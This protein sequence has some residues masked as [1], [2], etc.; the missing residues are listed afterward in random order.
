MNGKVNCP[1]GMSGLHWCLAEHDTVNSYRLR[2]GVGTVPERRPD[3]WSKAGLEWKG[4]AQLAVTSPV[5]R[6]SVMGSQEAFIEIQAGGSF[7]GSQ[8]MAGRI[9]SVIGSDSWGVRV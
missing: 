8:T 9:V 5:D 1:L 7:N 6:T 2:L 3:P 4:W